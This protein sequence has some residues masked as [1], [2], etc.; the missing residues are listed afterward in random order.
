MSPGA[1]PLQPLRI[2]ARW[3][4]LLG[5]RQRQTLVML[6]LALATSVE[7]LENIMFVFASSHIVGGIGADPRGFALVQAAYAVGSMLMILKQQ[8]LAQRFGYRYYLT[9]ALLLFMAG[10]F[11]AAT[12]HSLPQM[13]AARFV[14]GVGGG[15]LFTSCRILINVMFGPTDRPRASRVFMLGIFS[16]SAIGPAFA[17]A[18]IEHGVWQDIFYGVL[19][20][21]ALAA[22]GA[23]LLLPD[24]EPRE[25]M[26]GPALGPLLLFGVAIVTLQT[27]MTEARFDVFSHP[28]RLALIAGAGLALVGVFLWQQWHHDTPVLRLRALRHPVYLAGLGMY[29]VY[30]LIN[31]LS[32]YVFPIYA[33]QA[34]RF[35]LVT[36]GW[37][38]TFAALISLAGI[39]VYLRVAGRLQRKKPLMV[40]GLLLMAGAAWWLSMMPPDAGPAAIAWA[41]VGKGLF[42]VLVII[43][44]AGLTFRSLAGD[45]FAHGYRSKNLIRQIASSFASALGAVLLQ[46]RQFAVHQSL[47]GAL[48]QRPAQTEQWM[49]TVQT[50]LA[51]RGF[52]ATQA[53]Q[54]A[55]AQLGSLVEQ[56][57]RLVACE[58]L[59]RLIAVLALTAAVYMLVQRRLD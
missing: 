14:Q 44:I 41:L 58:D 38:N 23:W 34:L 15:A 32:G 3:L 49:Q 55:L 6:L 31:N 12:S 10:T 53:H 5:H 46:N 9:G 40:T 29:F 22:L 57:A 28:L 45:A 33:E 36:T 13:V 25:D 20:F 17:A 52:D 11:A 54:G 42:G 16:A 30:Y 56:Q 7:F 8:W 26:E 18:L 35:P 21:A 43:P 37:L 2:G 4:R 27:A 24:A 50:A 19:P 51:A 47:T 39:F 48:G 59:Y 1:S